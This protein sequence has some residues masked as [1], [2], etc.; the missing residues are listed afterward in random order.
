LGCSEGVLRRLL[1]QTL[2]SLGLS[3]ADLAGLA[4]V[5]HKREEA[6]L[7]ALARSLNLPLAWFAPE[8]LQVV[9]DRIG[10]VS[11]LALHATGAAS[12]AE[13]CALAQVEAL[14]GRRAN[15]HIGKQTSA[16]AT[17]AIAGVEESV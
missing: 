15:L 2:H 16:Q 11:H 14:S 6:G 8:Q 1:E 4:S 3:L 9:S 17:V 12:V 10:A 5:A 13:A 7:L